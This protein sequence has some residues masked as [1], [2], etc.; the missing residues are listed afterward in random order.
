[1]L[2]LHKIVPHYDGCIVIL[3]SCLLKTILTHISSCI[4]IFD[5][6]KIGAPVFI[7]NLRFMVGNYNE[8][9][10]L[11]IKIACELFVKDNSVY[12]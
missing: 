1:M 10:F 12:H 11:W 2:S 8:F 5:L 9:K 4:K 7:Y 6:K 3:V